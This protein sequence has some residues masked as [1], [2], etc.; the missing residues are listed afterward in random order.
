MRK[1]LIDPISGG[2][3]PKRLLLSNKRLVRAVSFPIS[4]GM[5]PE[6]LLFD[7]ILFEKQRMR[8]PKATIWA[9][10]RMNKSYN[11]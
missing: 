9:K 3:D 6:S 10:K 7:K 11:S 4:G 8:D 5:V 2:M 1:L